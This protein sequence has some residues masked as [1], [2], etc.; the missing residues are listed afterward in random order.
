MQKHKMELAAGAATQ[1]A[2]DQ[3]NVYNKR[4]DRKRKNV[5]AQSRLTCNPVQNGPRYASWHQALC[6]ETPLVRSSAPT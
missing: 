5:Y 2:T 6:K 3:P 1:A 4:V